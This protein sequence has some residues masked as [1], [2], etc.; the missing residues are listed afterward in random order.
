MLF[1]DRTS[2]ET[3]SR[4]ENEKWV[5]AALN[6]ANI[7][8]TVKFGKIYVRD[9]ESAVLA[10]NIFKTSISLTWLPVEINERYM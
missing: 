3:A 10:K 9:E 8:A 6:N 5:R 2:I 1:T 4:F 7:S